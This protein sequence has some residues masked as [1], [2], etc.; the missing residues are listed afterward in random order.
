MA[1]VTVAFPALLRPFVGQASQISI[2]AKTVH[3]ALMALC[4]R[5][6]ALKTLLFDEQGV[7]R[8]HV[9]CFHNE[10]NTRWSDKGLN[11]PLQTGDQLTLIQAVAGG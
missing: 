8:T 10:D 4:R 11:R 5:Y 3:S 9:L 2:Q 7:L 1:Q 6:P